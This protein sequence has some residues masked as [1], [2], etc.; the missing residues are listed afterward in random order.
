MER[1]YA[2]RVRWV[3]FAAALSGCGTN[4]DNIYSRG[5]DHDVLCGLNIDNKNA[6][7]NDAIALVLDRAQ[8]EQV[9]VHL[10]T[11]RPAGTVDESTIELVIAGAADRNMNFVTY[12]EL[13]EGTATEGLAFGFDDRDLDGWHPLRALFDLYGAKVTFFISEFHTLT[14]E[15]RAKLHDLA[16]DGHAIEYHSTSHENAATYARELGIDRYLAEDILPDL[17]AMRADGFDP[18]VFAYPFGAR[19]AETDAALLQQFRLLRA[20]HSTCPY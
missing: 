9:V 1:R 12:R 16:G 11:H 7:S 2:G 4:V 15:Q 8:V 10:Y 19:T 20:I 18:Q 6:V 17:E 5:A 14:P 3:V 13:A